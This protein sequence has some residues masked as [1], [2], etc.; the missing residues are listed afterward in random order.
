MIWYTVVVGLVGLVVLDYA[1]GLAKHIRVARRSGL[2]YVIALDQ[3]NIL[4]MVLFGTTLLPYMISWL[5]PWLADIMNDNLGSFRWRVKNRQTKRYGGVYL[6]VSPHGIRCSVG[7]AAVVSQ[8]VNARHDFPKPVFQYRILDMYGPNI[9]TCEDKEWSHHRRHTATTFHEKNNDLVWRESIRQAREM[10]DY[11]QETYPVNIP[12]GSGFTIQETRED[13]HKLTLNVISS[14]GF[15]VDMPFKPIPQDSLK[16]TEDIFKDSPTPPAG[17]DFTFRSVVSYMNV[18]IATM[19]LANKILPTWVPRV[20]LPFLKDDFAAYRDLDQYLQKLISVNK[21]GVT[22]TET[23]SNLIEGMLLS[24]RPD[25]AKDPGLTDREVIS[26]MHIFTIAGHE[27]TATT[28][29]FALLLLAL[30]QD[31]QDWVYNGIVEATK[32]E[33]SD[34]KDWDYERIFPKL[35]T[36]LC[37]MLETMRLYPPVITVPKWTG[38][39]PS[40]IHYRGK[41]YVLEPHVKVSLN[42][43]SLHYSEE[44]WGRDAALFQPQRWDV[45]NHE[46]FLAQ[47]ADMPGLAGPGLEYPTIHKPVRGAYLP[48]SD[49][50]RACLGK[51]FAQV[52]LVAALAVLLR[53]YRVELADNSEEGR[54]N[55]CRILDKSTSVLTLA[56]R[57]SVPL[58]FRKR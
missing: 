42:A 45:C 50:F 47:N 19:A 5:P 26:N 23:A 31:V 36:P 54:G 3:P 18:K 51:K 34:V 40:T 55:A 10:A 38:E 21:S 11:W 46:S 33:P 29:R 28:S 25:D 20:L 7:D 41:D 14:A 49:G 6:N 27:T 30:D 8:I 37:V 17:F 4:F 16:S 39:T 35:V 58:L 57:E 24:R 52:E 43:G 15:G 48:F 53:D 22:G 1:W 56:M 32:N 12:H 13:L 9:V 44:Y 2:P